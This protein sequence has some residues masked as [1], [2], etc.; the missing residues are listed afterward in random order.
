MRELERD[1]LPS[2]L[3]AGPLVVVGRGRVGGSLSKAAE[4]AGLQ[5]RLAAT[6]AAVDA[7]ADAGAVLLCVPDGAIAEVCGR[8]A[9]TPPPLVGH[10]SG[11][12]TLDALA[13]AADR[14]AATFSLHPL[15]TFADGDTRVDGNPAAIAGSNE[16]AVSFA[17]SLAEALGMRPFEVP[18]E[19]R[20]AYHAAA[21]IAS[22]LLIA[23]EES[24]AELFDR[25]G[26]DDARELLAPLVLRTA[27][28]WAERGPA[29]LTGPI[30]RG[31]HATVERH[32][33]ALAETAPE[34]VPLYE[35]LAVRAE[36]LAASA[37]E[38]SA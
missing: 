9:S 36:A 27:A 29:A 11:A 15:Q 17:R 37:S 7:C 30:A 2:P 23:L 33:A 38:V 19:S 28:N 20:A 35:A 18:E 5:L 34:L 1:S 12:S 21:A 8:I 24:A 14:G 31:D 25:I 13:A 22:N 6:D 10:V 26:I 3:S 32:R 16:E 4:L